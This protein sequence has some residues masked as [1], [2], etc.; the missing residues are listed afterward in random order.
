MWLSGPK[1][2]NNLQLEQP[3][4]KKNIIFHGNTTYI[5]FITTVLPTDTGTLYL[6]AG[7]YW[8]TPS[9]LRGVFTPELFGSLTMDLDWFSCLNDSF[10]LVWRRQSNLDVKRSK[11]L[12]QLWGVANPL[13]PFW[14]MQHIPEENSTFSACKNHKICDQWACDSSPVAFC[15]QILVF[16]TWLFDCKI[17][18]SKEETHQVCRFINWLDKNI[19]AVGVK[20]P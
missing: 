12:S 1:S 7:N 3:K 9:W 8:S 6:V 2:L 10:G 19:R 17:K 4:L 15:W 14:M 16:S 20:T 5:A 13:G 11:W 18:P